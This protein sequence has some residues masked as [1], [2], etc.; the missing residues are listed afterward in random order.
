MSKDLK[1]TIMLFTA[2]LI[3]GSSFIVMKSAV[4]FLTP[5]VL[6]FIRFTLASL[7][8][9]GLFFKKVK[10]FPKERIKGGLLT[11]CCLFGAYYVQTVGLQYTTPGKNA[12]LTAVY[13]AIVPFLVWIVY[14]KRPDKFNFLAAFLCVIGIG[15]ISLDGDLSMNIGDILTLC[16]GVLYAV[17]ILMTQHYSRDVDGSAFTT[18]Q[19]M[20]SAFIALIVSLL[21]EDLTI[22]SGIQSSIYFQIFYLS[23][24]ATAVTLVCQTVGQSYTSECKASLILSLESVFGVIFS[25]AF[26]GEEITLKILIGFILVFLAI[27]VSETKL[28]FLTSKKLLK[29][30]TILF[31]ILSSIS[32]IPANAINQPSLNAPYAY[33]YN[34]TTGQELYGKRMN[35]KIYPAS[36]TK[37][38]TALVA[39]DHIKDLHQVV[40]MTSYDFEGLWEAGASTANLK[41]GEKVT[42]YDLLHGIILPSGAD[43]CRAT[44]RLLFGSEKKMAEAMNNKAK[45]LGLKNTHFVNTTGLHNK[46]HYTTVHDMGVITAT[47]LKNKTFKGIF[48]K[49][50]YKTET[51]Q[52]YMASSILKLHWRKRISIA[53]IKGCKT[54][55]TNESKSCLT[56]LVKSQGNELVCVFAK[57]AGSPK[58][59]E[60]A[61]SVIEYYKNN[62]ENVTVIKKG[63]LLK[64]I[65]IKNGVQETYDIVAEKNV[66]LCLPKGYHKS[67]LNYEFIGDD[68]VEAP[69]QPKSSLGYVKVTYQGKVLK[70]IPCQMKE[71]ID[72]NN[73]AKLLRM[74]NENMMIII[75]SIASI[76]VFLA[77]L[78]VFM[79]KSRIKRRKKYKAYKKQ[80]H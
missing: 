28:S 41:V 19:F 42:Y 9:L 71:L 46:N 61:K 38:M 12:F 72:E 13:C 76:V 14:H 65:M 39:L 54:G 44:A 68:M 43:A 30:T 59:V 69:T 11:G 29:I 40:K 63:E 26:Y 70:K 23:F 55:Y 80:R 25:V 58:Y 66:S 67:D 32:I 34:L 5:A 45:K 56:C 64:T 36:M 79:K 15:F 52:H 18:F 73:R 7:I 31:I 37:V 20:G 53:H 1:G 48:C 47:A 22:I 60:D 10:A 49:R 50:S 77:L 27:V 17:H 2:A 21:S 33:V 57:E 75:L 74:I 62:Y 35:E 4:D 51:T 8:L 16:G 6:L 3:W 78:L 24:F